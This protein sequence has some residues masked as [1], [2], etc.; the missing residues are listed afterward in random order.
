MIRRSGNHSRRTFV[1][2][3]LMLFAGLVMALALAGSSSSQSQRAPTLRIVSEDGNRLPTVILT[4]NNIRALAAGT[5]YIGSANGGV[6]KT[7]NGG[8]SSSL[9][10]T[11]TGTLIF[12]SASNTGVTKHGQGTLK[13]SDSDAAAKQGQGT[14]VLT[15]GNDAVY[16]FKNLSANDFDRVSITV[17]NESLTLNGNGYMGRHRPANA[18]NGWPFKWLLIVPIERGTR[19]SGTAKGDKVKDTGREAMH[20]CDGK[21]CECRSDAACNELI[22]ANA[23]A[24]MMN[25]DNTG[26]SL[27]CYCIAR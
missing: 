12:P 23:C 10:K 24:S 22:S 2:S 7:T 14:L 17:N 16:E 26:N 15:A 21:F 9:V 1:F 18:M 4:G 3:L 13:N 25:C 6:W 11:G 19:L 20:S 5:T 8:Q 27:R